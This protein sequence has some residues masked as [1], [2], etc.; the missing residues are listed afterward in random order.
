MHAVADKSA[1]KVLR[2]HWDHFALAATLPLPIL[3]LTH[4]PDIACLYLGLSCAWVSTEILNAGGLPN[5]SRDWNS[6]AQAICIAIPL[7]AALFLAFAI[8]SGVQTRFPFPL[9]AILSTVPA[10]GLV[11]WLLARVKNPYH[12]LILAAS[13]VFLCKLAA[14][15]VARIV[16]G[17]HYI[18]EGYIA[19]DWTTAKLMITLF[20]TFSTTISLSLLLLD[21]RR[22]NTPKTTG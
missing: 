9:M 20:W 5:S 11:P 16:Y 13:I 1:L 4:R 12:T 14:C 19:A 10:L 6:K 17:P 3:L 22:Y 15:V 18:E 2:L 21:Y 7:M 8:A